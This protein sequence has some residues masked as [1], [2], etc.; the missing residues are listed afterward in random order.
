MQKVGVRDLKINASEIIRRMREEGESF[1]VTYRGE[2]V[3]RIVPLRRH[4]DE[5]TI[6]ASLRRWQ[7]LIDEIAEHADEVSADETMREIRRD[8]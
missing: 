3:G 8:L 2:T 5:E 1:E 7:A 6:E 4:S